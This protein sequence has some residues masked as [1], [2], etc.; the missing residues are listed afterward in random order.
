MAGLK[1]RKFLRAY[2]WILLVA[3]AIWLTALLY[4]IAVNFHPAFLVGIAVVALATPLFVGYIRRLMPRP[5]TAGKITLFSFASLLYL[6]A[7]LSSFL[8]FAVRG[9]IHFISFVAALFLLYMAYISI[10]TWL[11][12]RSFVVFTVDAATVIAIAVNVAFSFLSLHD[13]LISYG[14]GIL[15]DLAIVLVVISTTATKHGIISGVLHYIQAK[16][17]SFRRR[18]AK[19]VEGKVEDAALNDKL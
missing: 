4:L 18:R 1:A 6:A 8:F 13:L 10:R 15:V 19:A 14:S 7:M 3:G 11:R 9:R 16:I 17:S 12:T 2:G 5:W